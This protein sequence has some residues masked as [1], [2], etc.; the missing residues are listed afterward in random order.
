M[1]YHINNESS[2]WIFPIPFKSRCSNT[3]NRLIALLSFKFFHICAILFEASFEVYLNFNIFFN[4]CFF[5]V[6]LWWITTFDFPNSSFTDIL[7][8]QCYCFDSKWI[9]NI[10]LL[11]LFF[12]QPNIIFCLLWCSQTNYFVSPLRACLIK[13]T[14]IGFGQC[15]LVLFSIISTS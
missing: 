9:C 8:H 6:Y 3:S 13:W 14:Y 7:P 10:K 4:I 11:D 15:Y 2:F 5:N 1:K 12:F